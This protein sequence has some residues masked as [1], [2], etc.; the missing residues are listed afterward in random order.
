ML[1]SQGLELLDDIGSAAEPEVGIDPAEDRREAQ[2]L[3]ARLLGADEPL[4]IEAVEGLA[5]PQGERR[6][7][8][9]AGIRDVAGTERLPPET[10]EALELRHVER[11]AR[12][13]EDVPGR[14]RAQVA[15]VATSADR[16][17]RT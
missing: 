11:A 15:E 9:P 16:S 6:A 10:A 17:L 8:Q 7:E 1:A 14:S 12:N 4:A 2:R 13:V 3:E 5:S